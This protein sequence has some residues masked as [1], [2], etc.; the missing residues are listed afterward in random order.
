MSISVIVKERLP[1]GDRITIDNDQ[2]MVRFALNMKF[3]VFRE[4]FGGKP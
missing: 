2:D 1:S 4:L 3:N